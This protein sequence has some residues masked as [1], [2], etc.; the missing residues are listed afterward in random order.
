MHSQLEQYLAEV[1]SRLTPLPIARRNEELQEMRQHLQNAVIVNR[2]LG[3]SEDE[4]VQ[5]AVEQFGVAEELGTRIVCAWRRE[6]AISL[7]NFWGVVGCILLGSWLGDLIY[8][9]V[10]MHILFS[11]IDFINSH[12]DASGAH[13]GVS[14]LW[15]YSLFVAAVVYLTIGLITGLVLPKR[16]MDGARIAALVIGIGWGIADLTSNARNNWLGSSNILSG[17]AINIAVWVA[18][19]LSLV[20]GAW[21]SSR[22]RQRRISPQE[23]AIQIIGLMATAYVVFVAC[24]V[25][26]GFSLTTTLTN[27]LDNVSDG[28]FFLAIGLVTILTVEI[29][30]RSHRTNTRRA[31]V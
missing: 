27:L 29:R 22:W 7:G 13:I 9:P 16:A 2:E 17:F 24:C 8:K 26:D 14:I 5:S 15:G 28:V 20:A 19:A 10:S 23:F 3:Q 1:A 18:A 4:A 12:R 21:I 30:K 25:L 11:Y 31:S 6:K